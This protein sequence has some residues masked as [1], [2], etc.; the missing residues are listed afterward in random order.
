M[1]VEIAGVSWCGWF[2]LI[3]VLDSGWL[4]PFR[5]GNRR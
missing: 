1:D 5:I 2:A 3:L 4:R